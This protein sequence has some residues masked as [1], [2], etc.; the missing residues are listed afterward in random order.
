M[1]MGLNALGLDALGLNDHGFNNQ[2]S[3]TQ[4]KSCT[5]L[6]KQSKLISFHFEFYQTL[7]HTCASISFISVS[8]HHFLYYRV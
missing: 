2:T 3:F 4:Q 5:Y 1:S 7:K 6:K 8:H